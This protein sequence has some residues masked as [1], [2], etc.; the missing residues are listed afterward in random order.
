MLKRVVAIKTCT[1]ESPDL[2]RRFVR[3]A[4]IAASL[5]PNF[6]TNRVTSSSKAL[7]L[8]Y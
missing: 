3:E 8:N 1:S 5:W 2:R 7:Q 4:E 6:G